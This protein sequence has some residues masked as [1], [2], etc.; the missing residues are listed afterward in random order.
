MVLL[1]T[2]NSPNGDHIQTRRPRVLYPNILYTI[3]AD[4]SQ[5]GVHK[6]YESTLTDSYV[7]CRGSRIQ[8]LAWDKFICTHATVISQ[9][10]GRK[11]E[12][13]I[14]MSSHIWKHS[15]PVKL[16]RERLSSCLSKRLGIIFSTIHRH[17]L[18]LQKVVV[19]R[20]HS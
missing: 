19:F 4:P 18:G 13:R 9:P 14:K 15:G 8:G 10:L 6:Q 1:T 12:Q 20:V 16:L 5:W 2:R 7:R 17:A 11:G 3:S